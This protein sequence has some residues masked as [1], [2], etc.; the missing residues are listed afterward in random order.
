MLKTLTFV[1]VLLFTALVERSSFAMLVAVSYSDDQLTELKAEA[2]S[3]DLDAQYEL[4][5]I[6]SGLCYQCQSPKPNQSEADKWFR[7]A[8]EKG[9]AP[10]QRGLGALYSRVE[11]VQNYT[12]AEK[13]LRKAADQGDSTAQDLLGKLYRDGKGVSQNT[14]EA[15]NWFERAAKQDYGDA[16]T[17]LSH[18]YARGSTN[19]P[20]NYEEA[21]FWSLVCRR[22]PI[23]RLPNPFTDESDFTPNN[24]DEQAWKEV[25]RNLTPEIKADVE[26]RLQAIAPALDQ[27]DH[28]DELEFAR[29]QSAELRKAK[30][31]VAAWKTQ[32]EQG[33]VVAELKLGQY[34]DVGH[35]EPSN[36]AEAYQWFRKAAEQGSAQG[37]Q[38]LAVCYL[39]GNGTNRDYSEAARWFRKA[40]EQGLSYSQ[41]QLGQLYFDGKGVQKD[42]G[43][44]YFW[45]SIAL[46]QTVPPRQIINW[47]GECYAKSLT[48]EQKAAAD[49]RIK[50][51][52][53]PPEHAAAP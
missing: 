4:G 14:A 43:E 51:W 26:K 50:N 52:K 35:Y 48:A 11:S 47:P 18:L 17:D 5:F 53:M 28:R 27:A 23:M 30:A 20:K 3:G 46:K 21:Y 10:A 31:R 39:L 22:S 42:N 40:A 2:E 38:S 12:E 6:Y 49:K 34:Y 33:S 1:L 37:A 15:V 45:C 16:C 32:A 19:L 44:A 24:P 29:R 13:W 8:A 7:R 41:H 25:L 36:H 9:Y